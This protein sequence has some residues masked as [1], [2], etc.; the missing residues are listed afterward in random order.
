MWLSKYRIHLCWL[1]PL[2]IFD[3][4]FFAWLWKRLSPPPESGESL[5]PAGLVGD[6]GIIV[7]FAYPTEQQLDRW[8]TGVFQPTAS[9]RPESA[10]YGSVRTVQIGKRLFSSFHE[11]VDIAP[12]KRDKAGRP[13]DAVFSAADGEVVYLNRIAGNSN[14][15]KYIVLAHGDGPGRLYTLYAHLHRIAPALRTGLKIGQGMDLGMMGFTSTDHILPDH[16]HLHFETGL[17]LNARFQQWF[18]RQKLSPDHG[19]YSG[20]NLIGIDPL[21]VYEWQE[22]N[23][24]EYDLFAALHAMPPAFEIVLKTPH[25]LDFFRRYPKLWQDAEFKA[26]AMVI[27]C[28][29]NGLPLIGR[30][31]S[32][33]ETYELGRRNNFVRRVDPSIL[34]RNGCRLV[35]NENGKWRLGSEGK[36]WLAMLVY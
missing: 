30:L 32:K 5:P 16:G 23:G 26:G 20:W 31:A 33:D 21:S 12:L 1:V 8:N 36:K 29:E 22:E 17:M 11:G 9:G 27:A 15:G 24:R 35:V 7:E 28:S 34:G 18:K 4:V 6:Q 3:A 2:L 19:N 25:Q 13:Q 10:F 14:Y